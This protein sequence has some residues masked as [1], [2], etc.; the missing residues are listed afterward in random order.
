M[1]TAVRLNLLGRATLQG[2]KKKMA[3]VFQFVCQLR[4]LSSR[5]SLLIKMNG[6]LM[7]G[8]VSLNVTFVFIFRPNIPLSEDCRVYKPWRQ[9]SRVTITTRLCIL[10]LTFSFR[11][12]LYLS[13]SP[14][15]PPSLPSSFF[16]YS[17]LCLSH[18]R[19][20]WRYLTASRLYYLRVSLCSSPPVA[21]ASAEHTLGYIS[22]RRLREA[23]LSTVIH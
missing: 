7:T 9:A 16:F 1:H 5:L 12:S 17:L 20:S 4:Y 18:Q 8:A 23:L 11:G 14:C 21:F 15:F 19:Q 13:I 22:Y 10:S 6:S 3:P 2:G